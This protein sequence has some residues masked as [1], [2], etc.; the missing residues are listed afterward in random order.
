MHRQHGAA[1]IDREEII[2]GTI[3]KTRNEIIRINKLSGIERFFIEGSRVV[4]L[5]RSGVRTGLTMT[6]SKFRKWSKTV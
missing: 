2:G 3:M 5:D 6:L 4:E 1:E